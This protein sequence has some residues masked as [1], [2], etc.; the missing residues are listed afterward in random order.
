MVDLGSRVLQCLRP[1]KW[2]PHS[3]ARGSSSSVVRSV[4]RYSEDLGSNPARSLDF[5]QGSAHLSLVS[6]S[7]GSF[8]H[9]VSAPKPNIQGITHNLNTNRISDRS[10]SKS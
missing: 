6:S 5:F 4:D 7:L 2:C 3:S 10:N 1:C 9:Y 8:L